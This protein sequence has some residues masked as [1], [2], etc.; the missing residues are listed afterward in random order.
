MNISIDIFL[1]L[2]QRFSILLQHCPWYAQ[3]VEKD[4]RRRKEGEDLLAFF[5]GDWNG[6]CI[7]HHCYGCC[8]DIEDSRNRAFGLISKLVMR[9]VKTPALNRWL[10]LRD[11]APLV[12]FERNVS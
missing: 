3:Y 7:V 4:K 11:V 9:R 5:T 6:L 12:C 2:S 1:I 10:H 8:R